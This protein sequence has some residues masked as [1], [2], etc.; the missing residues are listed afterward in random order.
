MKSVSS[1]VPSMQ[2]AATPQTHVLHLPSRAQAQQ[3]EEGQVQTLAQGQSCSP[4]HSKRYLTASAQHG[5]AWVEDVA[6]SDHRQAAQTMIKVFVKKP[7]RA[8]VKD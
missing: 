1:A 5:N 2:N 6:P 3:Y 8:V 7:R 4:S